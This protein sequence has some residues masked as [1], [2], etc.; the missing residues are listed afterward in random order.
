MFMAH[1]FPD[2]FQAI[3][4]PKQY[5]LKYARKNGPKT[6]KLQ[7]CI[8]GLSA[9][10]GKYTVRLSS[11]A[12]ST[13]ACPRPWHAQ[14]SRTYR[15][16]ARA[17]AHPA[18]G[19]VLR[20]KFFACRPI[21]VCL[22]T[23]AG[24]GADCNQLIAISSVIATARLTLLLS[25]QPTPPCP[26]ASPLPAIRRPTV[27]AVD[28]PACTRRMAV[29][30][31]A[32]PPPPPPLPTPLQP[33]PPPCLRLSK[34]LHVET[35]T[36]STEIHGEDP[37]TEAPAAAGTRTTEWE[38]IKRDLP[39]ERGALWRTRTVARHGGCCCAR[40]RR[41]RADRGRTVRTETPSPHPAHARADAATDTRA[42]GR[43]YAYCQS[44]RTRLLT[45]VRRATCAVWRQSAAA[46]AFPCHG[47]E[48]GRTLHGGG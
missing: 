8:E 3:K 48:G 41:S 13:C 27:G 47:L 10:Q 22:F 17:C 14:G 18:A 2:L 16:C 37:V 35:C 26:P 45:T 15:V 33:P 19:L 1:F 40:R 38:K 32:P 4:R 23:S 46:A 11:T 30:L 12:A 34:T 25:H 5:S 9:I 28:V 43:S 24:H 21:E 44:V 42:H 39:S 6:P 20:H 7:G 29:T 31:A 36:W